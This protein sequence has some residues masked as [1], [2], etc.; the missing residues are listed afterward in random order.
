VKVPDGGTI[1]IG[2]LKN[3]SI[4]DRRSVTPWLSKIPLLGFFFK[5][6]GDSEEVQHLMIIITAHITDLKAEE[7][8]FR[9]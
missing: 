6:E 8:R 3:I 2:G 4:E 9:R 1:V 7:E 5:R